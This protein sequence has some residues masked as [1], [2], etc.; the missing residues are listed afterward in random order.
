MKAVKKTV[1]S[2]TFYLENAVAYAQKC[3][4]GAAR[5]AEIAT[6]SSINAQGAAVSA[7]NCAQRA[8]QLVKEAE[9]SQRLSMAQR[10]AK[11]AEDSF[12]CAQ[13]FA[14]LTDSFNEMAISMF[15]LV[16]GWE[17]RNRRNN[18]NAAVTAAPIIARLNELRAFF[19]VRL[20]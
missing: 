1:S 11:G 19:R 20:Q 18:R 2:H 16:V 17:K 3:V 15:P 13:E 8:V 4:E 6:E 14:E 7:E 10:K 5:I 9:S 12:Y